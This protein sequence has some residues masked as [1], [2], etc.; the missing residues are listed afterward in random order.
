LA[1]RPALPYDGQ[2]DEAKAEFD[3][4]NSMNKQADDALYK[5]IQNGNAHPPQG[6]PPPPTGK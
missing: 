6:Q 4:A 5:K 3:K 1:P 2:K